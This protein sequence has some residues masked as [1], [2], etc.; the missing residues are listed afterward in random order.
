MHR[1]ITI[2]IS[3]SRQIVKQI[4][5]R[6]VIFLNTEKQSIIQKLYVI[7]KGQSLLVPENLESVPHGAE[8]KGHSVNTKT[9]FIKNSVLLA[10][11]AT[12]YA[13]CLYLTDLLCSTG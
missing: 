12:L 4:L 11:Y 10:L 5:C 1:K 6:R 8:R 7:K 2:N 9:F 3:E 13:L